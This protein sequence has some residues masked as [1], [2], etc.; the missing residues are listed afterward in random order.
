MSYFLVYATGAKRTEE[1]M[2]DR[3][4]YRDY[5]DRVSFFVPLPPRH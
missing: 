3:E 5:Q 4:A 2:Q 1:R